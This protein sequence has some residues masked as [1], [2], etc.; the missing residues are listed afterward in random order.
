MTHRR[1]DRRRFLALTGATLAAPGLL[2]AASPT[3]ALQGAAY[4]T[5]WR[6]VLPDTHVDRTALHGRLAAALEAIDRQM[7]PWKPDTVLSRLN[8]AP[9]GVTPLPAEMARVTRAALSLARE[10]D[11]HFDPTVGPLVA[12]WGFGPIRGGESRWQDL[13]LDGDALRR[14]DAGLT[15]D[16]CGIAK[17]RALDVLAGQLR[18]A[19]L[20]DHLIEIGGELLAGG[21]HPTGRDWT[22]GVEHPVPGHGGLAGHLPLREGAIA[23]SGTARQS[24]RLAGHVYSHI[25]DP[26]RHAPVEAGP[27][28]SVSVRAPTAMEADGWATALM[29]A[30]PAA[31]PALA[32]RR[33]R[34]ALFLFTTS[35]GLRAEITGDVPFTQVTT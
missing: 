33:G 35:K 14:P 5:T 16:L 30:G 34:D 28:A 15:L 12:R 18:A 3:Q 1:I 27:L 25:I 11:G 10:S 26:A 9:A 17:G 32:R 19:G 24:L 4:G 2:H 21:R 13:T 29:A 22:A 7:S 31:G 8:R 20:D 23:T 6:V